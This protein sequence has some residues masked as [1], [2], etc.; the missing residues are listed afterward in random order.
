M[1]DTATVERKKVVQKT[2]KIWAFED[3]AVAVELL[4]NN[5]NSVAL[6]MHRINA[7][8]LTREALVIL[9]AETSGVGKPAVREVLDAM[10]RLD[11]TYLKGKK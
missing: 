10:S 1:A 3:E 7:A 9:L 5:I 2:L 6:A 11:K 8:N 4:A